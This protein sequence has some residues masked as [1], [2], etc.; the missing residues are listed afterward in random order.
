LYPAGHDRPR[1]TE[2]HLVQRESNPLFRIQYAH[3]RTRALVR[4]A[5]DLGFTP[6]PGDLGTTISAGQNG[7]A[8]DDLI[9]TLGEYTVVLAAAARHRAPDRLARHLLRTG[10]AFLRFQETVRIL[11]MGD[12]KP[13]AAH[14]ARLALAEATGTVLA[15]G[16]A[17]L[18]VDAPDT[19]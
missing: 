14:R 7:R 15:G 2:E 1:I 3:A 11:P 19:M 8:A 9:T 18:G 12:E 13:S 16:F 6:A 10:D 17:L 5:A 4:N